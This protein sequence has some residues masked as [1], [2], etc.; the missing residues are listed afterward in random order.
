MY[1]RK[2]NAVMKTNILSTRNQN[3]TYNRTSKY[4]RNLRVLHKAFEPIVNSLAFCLASQGLCLCCSLVR[5][6]CDPIIQLCFFYSFG[7]LC[8]INTEKLHFRKCILLQKL[9]AWYIINKICQLGNCNKYDH[10]DFIRP[11]YRGLVKRGLSI[12]LN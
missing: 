5:K 6:K 4:N 2:S 1:N 9:K 8:K 7:E 10:N 11:N 3:S 12:Y